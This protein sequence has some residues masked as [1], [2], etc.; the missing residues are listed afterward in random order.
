MEFKNVEEAMEHI[1]TMTEEMEQLRMERDKLSQ[2]N[3][4]LKA[5]NENLRTVNQK[6]F[7]K[8]IAQDTAETGGEEEEGDEIPTCE[9]FAKTL[10]I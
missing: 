3:E 6:Y 4:S 8:L 7:N 10:E 9:E 5:D 1:V 2:D